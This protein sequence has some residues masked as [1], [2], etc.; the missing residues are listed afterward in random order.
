MYVCLCMYAY[1]HAC[2]R[3]CLS[4]WAGQTTDSKR[5]SVRDYYVNQIRSVGQN[6][7]G[8]TIQWMLSRK[9]LQ[10]TAPWYTRHHCHIVKFT[11]LHMHEWRKHITATW[12][13]DISA[14][15]SLEY[16]AFMWWILA[17]T[18][19]T[20]TNTGTPMTIWNKS[21]FIITLT[22]SILCLELMWQHLARIP[23]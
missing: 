10:P 15:K 21:Q 13:Y 7:D 3:I 17:H 8:K 1:M 22:Y 12:N 9:L 16:L 20:C 18:H 14:C 11:Y 19:Y 6:R 5:R 4:L 23:Q 2:I